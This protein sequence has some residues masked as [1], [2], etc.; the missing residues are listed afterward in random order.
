MRFDDDIDNVLG[1]AGASDGRPEVVVT[2]KKQLHAIR[3]HY[4]GSRLIATLA[5]QMGITIEE[6]LSDLET[7]TEPIFV[8]D[9]D[10]DEEADI[11]ALTDAIGSAVEFEQIAEIGE[12]DRLR[13]DAL[14]DA[15]LSMKARHA[16]QRTGKITGKIDCRDLVNDLIRLRT[17]AT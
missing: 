14:P 10:Y 11:A 5:E 15:G 4:E 9:P 8:V 7:Q 17:Q 2:S 6:L 12:D 13:A 16:E 1:T 3:S